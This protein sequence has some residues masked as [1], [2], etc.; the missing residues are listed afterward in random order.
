MAEQKTTGAGTT[1]PR[2]SK[3]SG[4]T[5]SGNGNRSR[6]YAEIRAAR[7]A[8]QATGGTGKNTPAPGKKK[9]GWI[10]SLIYAGIIAVI[11]RTFFFEAFRIPTG[12]M[13]NTLL[14]GDYLFVNKIGY[15]IETPKYIPFTT[16]EIPHLHIP[17]GSVHRGDVVVFEYPGDQDVVTPQQKN[18]N[19][20]KRCI[21][22][23]GDVIQVINKQ[24]YVNGKIFPNPPESILEPD[25]EKKGVVDPSIFPNGAPWNK[26]NYGPIQV[27]KKGMI[28]PINRNDIA[29]WQVFIE[30]E[31]HKVGMALN[32]QVLIDG[33]PAT[34]Y[35]VQ[36]DYLWMMGDNRD[37]SEDSRYWGF[38]P[39]DNVIGSAFIVYWSWYNPPASMQGD[40]YDPDEVQKFHIRWDRIGHLIH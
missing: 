24:V 4:G 22:L 16:I 37:D 19:Y 17:T 5:P 7:D 26:D 8:K 27:P 32:G 35:K 3:S 33:K 29:R 13:K 21:G 20:I 12:S 15:F 28:I 18:V 36:R 34:Q 9:E 38:A 25:T 11:I 2:Q 14:V 39:M 23:P 40:G 31:G 1:P 10:R 6:S 30:R